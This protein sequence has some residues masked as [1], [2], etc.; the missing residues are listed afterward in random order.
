MPYKITTTHLLLLALLGLLFLPLLFFL[1]PLLLLTSLLFG[2]RA[3]N[4]GLGVLLFLSA[5]ARVCMCACM[6]AWAC[7]C[8]RSGL[9][10]PCCML[11]TAVNVQRTHLQFGKVHRHQGG[12]ALAPRSVDGAGHPVRQLSREA[13][14]GPCLVTRYVISRVGVTFYGDQGGL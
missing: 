7:A 13:V 2:G 12:F 10:T 11:N 3:P 1:Q 6:S 9:H 8:A 5:C 14:H 4:L